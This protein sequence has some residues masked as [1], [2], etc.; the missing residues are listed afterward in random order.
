MRQLKVRRSASPPVTKETYVYKQEK[1]IPRR[2]PQLLPS[3]LAEHEEKAE[4]MQEK[5]QLKSYRESLHLQSVHLQK[6]VVRVLLHLEIGLSVSV[7]ASHQVW[8]VE[9][10]T[11]LSL[12]RMARW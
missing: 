2:C 10:L 8:K 5:L 9:E 1:K 12:W 4:T 7:N 3:F 11:R 6:H